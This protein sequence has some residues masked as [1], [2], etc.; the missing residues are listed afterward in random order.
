MR[1]RTIGLEVG[2]LLMIQADWGAIANLEELQMV[3]Q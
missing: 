3:H 2:R 1:L